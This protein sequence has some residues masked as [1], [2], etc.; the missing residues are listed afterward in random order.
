MEH[1]LQTQCCQTKSLDSQQTSTFKRNISSMIVSAYIILSQ[2]L[3]KLY[4]TA[5][6][7]IYCTWKVIHWR[8]VILG[9]SKQLNTSSFSNKSFLLFSTVSSG[10]S[11]HQV[12][13]WSKKW[14][15]RKWQEEYALHTKPH[16][17]QLETDISGPL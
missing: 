7:D 17:T 9:A 10:V 13:L 5:M 6:Q 11:K 16:I 14:L 4:F 15:P 8:C 2:S 12:S 1:A 3:K